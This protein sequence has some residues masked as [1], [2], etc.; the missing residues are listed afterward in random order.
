MGNPFHI[1]IVDIFICYTFPSYGK[2]QN[3]VSICIL[4]HKRVYMEYRYY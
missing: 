2:I 3:S 4:L 1:D